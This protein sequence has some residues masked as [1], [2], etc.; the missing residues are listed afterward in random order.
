MTRFLSL[1]LG[2]PEPDFRQGLQRLE[3]ANGNP[4]QDVRLSSEVLQATRRKFMEL[5]LDPA[6]TT[7]QELYRALQQR[8][9][10][11]DARLTKKLRSAAASHVSAEADVVA[12][13]VHVLKELPDSKRCFALKA[14]RLKTLLKATPPRRAMK[15]LGYRSLESMLKHEAPI[16][17]LA[18]AW[19]SEGEAWQKRFLDQY[20]KLQ[21]GDFE[22]RNIGL[23]RLDSRRWQKLA[24]Q[25]V[26]RNKH[27]L[28]SFRELGAVVFLPLPCEVPEGVVTVS[29]SLALHELNEIR[30]TSTFLK[31]S[32]VKSDFGHIVRSI[33]A[34]EAKLNSE[35]LDQP[36]PWHLVQ[37][38]Y[39]RLAGRFREEVFE[40]YLQLEDMVW[41]PVEKTLSAIE[42]SLDFWHHTA[43]LGVLDHHKPVSF[44]IVDAALNLCNQLPYEQRVVHY[45]QRSLWHELLLRYLKHQPVENTLLAEL[46]P[47]LV[48]ETV[49]S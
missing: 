34:D 33:A 26:S 32:Q 7:S 40:P 10:A 42:P 44:N 5:G 41:H 25:T 49:R 21:S 3:N 16:S 24:S 6:D 45:F 46:Q 11:D 29:L 14:S 30:A 1:S 19:L 17:V 8:V 31:L 48:E 35:L 39:A 47:E 20:K 4:S 27:N 37:R 15:Q 43:H 22:S 12:G 38:Y 13:L 18:A 28:I 36:V 2:A 23:I 9:R